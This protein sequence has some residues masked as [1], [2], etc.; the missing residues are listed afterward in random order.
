MRIDTLMSAASLGAASLITGPTPANEVASYCFAIRPYRVTCTGSIR[1][2]SQS[3]PVSIASRSPTRLFTLKL[4][5]L[6]EKRKLGCWATGGMPKAPDCDGYMRS[7][8]ADM[9]VWHVNMVRALHSASIEIGDIDMHYD[10]IYRLV[11]VCCVNMWTTDV[12]AS[13]PGRAVRIGD[14]RHSLMCGPAKDFRDDWARE[15][16][17]TFPTAIESNECTLEPEPEEDDEVPPPPDRP[18]TPPATMSWEVF[19]HSGTCTWRKKSVAV[20]RQ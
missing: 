20:Q 1:I 5:P 4:K 18:T 12:A 7:Q 13:W 15:C 6:S 16:R 17:A 11:S 8:T 14:I 19:G 9:Q 2:G 3:Y 10:R